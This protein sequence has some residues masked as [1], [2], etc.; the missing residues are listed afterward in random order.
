[1]N[2]AVTIADVPGCAAAD[3]QDV[4]RMI[5]GLPADLQ[6]AAAWSSW[7]ASR[8]PT[9]RSSLRIRAVLAAVA[10]VIE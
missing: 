3:L 10:A 5:C 2:D 1:M 7:R 8:R 6:P 4:A 9:M